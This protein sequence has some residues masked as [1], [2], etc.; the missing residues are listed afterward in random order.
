MAAG[1]RAALLLADSGRRAGPVGVTRL[2]VLP[3]R[4]LRRIRKRISSPSASPTRSPAR[5]RASIRW[6]CA[7]ASRRSR[8]AA[9]SADLETVAAKADVDVV[10]AGTLLRAGDELRVTTQLVEA[11]SGAV[12]WSHS[13]QV[14]L[15]DIFALQDELTAGMV[16]AFRCR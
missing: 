9:D 13:S 15:G 16:E 8:F 12:V 10:L 2:I 11:P 3:F 1:A 14:P 7:R 5:C 4:M 6:S